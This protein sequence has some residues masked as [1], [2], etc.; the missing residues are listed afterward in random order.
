MQIQELFINEN[1][2]IYFMNLN[3]LVGLGRQ[4]E[5]NGL[6]YLL[7]HHFKKDVELI[8]DSNGKPFVNKSNIHISISHSH[9]LLALIV[10]NKNVAIDVELITDKVQR[11]KTKFLNQYELNVTQKSDL[12]TLLIYWSAKETMFKHLGIKGKS[13]KDD[14]YLNSFSISDQGGI[15]NGITDVNNLKIEVSMRYFLKDNFVVVH[16]I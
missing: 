12:L 2:I 14:F 13:L 15:I 9:H 3:S 4:R 16:T 7:N 6:Q 1:T 8:Y 10:S 5:K 11:V